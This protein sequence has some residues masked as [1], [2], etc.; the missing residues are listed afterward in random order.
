MPAST[1]TTVTASKQA[2]AA[3]NAQSSWTAARDA[4]SA[5]SINN[6]T[7]ST[8]VADAVYV[9]FSSGKGGGLYYVGRT[10]LFFDLSGVNGTITAMSL[11]VT[12]N[13]N[14]TAVVG[15]A[16]ST[17]FGGSGG[18]NLVAADFDNWNPDSPTAYNAGTSWSTGLNTMTM[19]STAVSDANT[20]SYLNVVLVERYNDLEDGTPTTDVTKQSGVTFQNS[21]SPIYLDITYTPSATGYSNNVMG[22]SSSSIANVIGVSTTSIANVN[23]AT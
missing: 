12:G 8:S 14:T 5:D 1:T 22:V 20:N 7:T 10:F 6:Y 23:G 3:K 4:T 21:S 15:A 2:T 9:I 19:N 17:A 18:S 13:T 16:R 11:K